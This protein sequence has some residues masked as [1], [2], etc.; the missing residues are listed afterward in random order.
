M[1]NSAPNP[2][3][4]KPATFAEGAAV[5]T[6]VPAAPAD[7]VKAATP[8]PTDADYRREHGTYRAT[9]HLYVGNSR[10]VASGGSV[11]AS[12]PRLHKGPWGDG[13]I[14]EGAVELTGD[15]PAPT[16]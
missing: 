3:Q 16:A 1:T 2:D 14:A 12:H 10:A 15:Y 8:P 4:G 5:P 11:P 6:I 9:R 13:W 7:A